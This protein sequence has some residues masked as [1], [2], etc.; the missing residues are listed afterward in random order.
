MTPLLRWII[1]TAITI[2]LVLISVGIYISFFEY[3]VYSIPQLVCA[4][5][6]II[7]GVVILKVAYVVC[8]L[9]KPKNNAQH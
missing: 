8:C 1:R 2:A 9:K 4:H 3:E 7:L 5:I 6:S